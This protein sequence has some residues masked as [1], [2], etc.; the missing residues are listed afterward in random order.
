M[1]EIPIHPYPYPDHFVV[2]NKT[3]VAN[4]VTIIECNI[5]SRFFFFFCS[6][7]TQRKSGKS[8][9]DAAANRVF[10]VGVFIELSCCLLLLD[11]RLCFAIYI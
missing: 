3:S 11:Y 1:Y 5:I 6:I 2:S 4:T 9:L 10:L 7:V 8:K